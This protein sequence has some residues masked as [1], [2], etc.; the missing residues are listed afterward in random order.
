MY[1]CHL[2]EFSIELHIVQFDITDKMR[3]FA[4]FSFYFCL[5]LFSCSHTGQSEFIYFFSFYLILLL[6]LL[7]I[8]L[9]L[10]VCVYIGLVSLLAPFV[11]NSLLSN[12]LW[13]FT[14]TLC[15]V[16]SF[17]LFP[18]ATD[19]SSYSFEIDICSMLLLLPVHYVGVYRICDDS[20]RSESALRLSAPDVRVWVKLTMYWDK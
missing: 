1:S 11:Y 17:F 12:P 4:Y 15:A 5:I 14:S 16:Y 19:T 6:L 20:K 7:Y 10:P 9:S 13:C 2:F 3:I 18:L 8:S